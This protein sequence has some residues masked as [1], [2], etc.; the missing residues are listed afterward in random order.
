MVKRVLFL[1]KQRES[2]GSNGFKSSGLHN[3]VKFVSEMLNH[4]GIESK[5]VDVMDAN[6]IDREVHHYRPT[7]VSIEAIW[8]MPEKFAE[9]NRL[10]PR[11]KWVIRIHSNLPFL[12]NEGMAL[13]KLLQYLDYRKVAIAANALQAFND[14]RAL[15]GM[16]HGEA[17]SQRVLYLPNYYDLAECHHGAGN[18]PD[19]WLDVG[20]FGAVRPLKNHLVQAVAAIRFAEEKGLPLRFHINAGRVEQNG[21]QVLTSLRSLFKELPSYYQLVEH[22]W[23]SYDRF[24]KLV[25][26][27]DIGLQV[28]L[29][30]TFNIVSADFTRVNVPMV[31]SD[32]VFWAWPEI[33]ANPLSSTDITRK[34]HLAL[35]YGAGKNKARLARYCHQSEI[36]WLN[37]LQDR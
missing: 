18:Q 7:H 3:S 30:E 20:C 24:L 22:P 31:V 21:G 19:G 13:A 9:L 6:D 8:V 15:M 29:T 11:V 25:R 5:V 1:C 17:A 23:H 12:A 16:I 37:Y 35:K 27:M 10:H 36:E 14:L 32:S 34:M 4:C 28:S 26:T 33:F 2:Y